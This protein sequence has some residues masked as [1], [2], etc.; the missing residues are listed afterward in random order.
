[1][2]DTPEYA[3]LT[4]VISRLDSKGEIAPIAEVL[5]LNNAILR[6]L[7]WR[8]C[9]MTEGF[10]HSI[11]TGIPE[12]TWR[13]LYEGVQPTKSTTASVV[14]VTSNLEMTTQV[15]CDL[16]DINGNTYQWR[17][18]EQRP[19]MEGMSNAV[20]QAMYY[21]DND[22]DIRKFT[23]LATR[24]N[25]LST[26]VPC[27]KNCVSAKPTGY[28]GGQSGF[29]SAFIVNLEQFIGLYPK[30]SMAGLRHTDMGKS[31]VDAPDGGGKML[32]YTDWYKWQV[33]AALIDWRGCVRVCNI[34]IKD[35]V[36]DLEPDQLIKTLIK[37]KNRIP[38]S[39]RRNLVMFC[40]T[41]L[42]TALETAAYDKSSSVVKIVEA[43]EQFRTNFFNIPIEA[44]DAISLDEAEVK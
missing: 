3:T 14:D 26:K 19:S 7:K 1:M 25:T 22:K 43:A 31:S 4:D 27:S 10:K 13:G 21:G 28:A 11:R 8:E 12:P 36:V 23:G 16:A 35:G 44:D 32:A 38:A 39:L 34:P 37:A 24:Y 17:L 15:D 30:G 29:T 40:P 6:R 5:T 42:Y 33:G 2:A 18:T 41:E 9:N 20:A